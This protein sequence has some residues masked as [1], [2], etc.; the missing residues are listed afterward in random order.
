LLFYVLSLGEAHEEVDNENGSSKRRKLVTKPRL[1][2]LLNRDIR[3]W[4]GK[5][6][7]NV[8]NSANVGMLW[9]FFNKYCRKDCSVLHVTRVYADDKLRSLQK[10]SMNC[11][12]LL[13]NTRCTTTFKVGGVQ[14]MAEYFM[15][16]SIMIPDLAIML[17]SSEVLFGGSKDQ[18][19]GTVH[20][21]CSIKG[22]RLFNI[23]IK[24]WMPSM[25]HENTDDD[26][27]VG[28]RGLSVAASSLNSDSAIDELEETHV[29]EQR[30]PERVQNQQAQLVPVV[31][32]VSYSSKHNKFIWQ[33][34]TS[35]FPETSTT[36]EAS[37]AAGPAMLEHEDSAKT[38]SNDFNTSISLMTA[39][40]HRATVASKFKRCDKKAAAAD[41]GSKRGPYANSYLQQVESAITANKFPH[42]SNFD[43]VFTLCLDSNNFVSNIDFIRILH[44]K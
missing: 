21:Y 29:E 24:K 35:D 37:G 34:S 25:D 8:F 2:R 31:T 11:T 12:E 4:Y 10:Q 7:T 1:P 40:R 18:G 38:F 13:N 26:F 33:V 19:G 16:T 14:A 39:K 9:S 42:A 22:T 20:V 28:F 6:L 32:G 43:C 41:V 44:S 30:K 23:P 3:K 36:A 5:M 17:H 27:V 15:G